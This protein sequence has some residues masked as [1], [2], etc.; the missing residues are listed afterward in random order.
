MIRGSAAALLVLMGT[1]GSSANPRVLAHTAKH[2][3]F[4]RCGEL[5]LY[6]MVDE[7]IAAVERQ[8]W[9]T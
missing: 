4:A 7:Q 5:N 6:G 1:L 3:A 2:Y 8:L 9:A